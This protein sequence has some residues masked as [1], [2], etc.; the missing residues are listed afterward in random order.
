MAEQRSAWR[1][2]LSRF[3]IDIRLQV[4]HSRTEEHFPS[5]RRPREDRT[6]RRN[7]QRNGQ[8]GI[9]RW[10][11]FQFLQRKNRLRSSYIPRFPEDAPGVYST[12]GIKESEQ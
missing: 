2:I 4:Q 11:I 8:E 1:R 6:E 3:A 12:I 5:E 7:A 9:R 10:N